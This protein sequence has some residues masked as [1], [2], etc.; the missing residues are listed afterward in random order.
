MKVVVVGAAGQVGR[1]LVRL[2]V[3][4]GDTVAA[5]YKARRPAADLVPLELLDK[6]DAAACDRVLERLRPDVVIDTG[7][8]HNVDYCETHREE[9]NAV[10]RDGTR[11]L[12]ES[13]RRLGAR[14]VF[15]STDFVFDGAGPTPYVETETP[16]PQSVYAESKLAGELATLATDPDN[17]VVRPSVIYSWL[18]TRER[19]ESSS[20]K[21]LNF[22]TWLAE[23]VARGRPVRIIN[24]QVASPTLASD[25]A[26]A[27]LALVDRRCRGTFHTAGST[28]MD[29]HS[30]SVQLVSRLGLDASLVHPVATAELNQKAPR[31]AVSSLASGRL[32]AETGYR[33]MDLPK[34]LDRFAADFR[35]DPG[36]SVLHS[37]AGA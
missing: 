16:H 28:A 3:E 34:A 18:D 25:L 32:S 2:A 17:L 30:F 11:F 21:G 1:N 35:A 23:E 22:G 9:A 19:A 29:R 13:S 8:M 20:G 36:T 5:T 12:A 6:T 24:D 10:N 15:I 14:F 7:A 37:P 26:G 27:I 4:R 33:M 31:P